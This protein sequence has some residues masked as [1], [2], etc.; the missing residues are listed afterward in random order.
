MERAF[1]FYIAM[2]KYFLRLLKLKS[3]PNKHHLW[4]KKYFIK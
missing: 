4:L 1:L 3:L 2:Q